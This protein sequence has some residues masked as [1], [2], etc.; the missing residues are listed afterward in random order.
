MLETSALLLLWTVWVGCS[1]NVLFGKALPQDPPLTFLYTVL[2]KKGYTFC[3][4]SIENGT[5]T[6]L[7]K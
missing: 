6:G 5:C 3:E 4:P 1:I 7:S 2:D